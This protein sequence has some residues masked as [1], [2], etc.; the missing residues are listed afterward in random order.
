MFKMTQRLRQTLEI[1]PGHAATM[2]AETQDY[3]CSVNKHSGFFKLRN[4]SVIQDCQHALLCCTKV[5]LCYLTCGFGKWKCNQFNGCRC[6]RGHNGTDGIDSDKCCPRLQLVQLG[7]SSPKF[8]SGSGNLCFQFKFPHIT[9][10]GTERLFSL[11]LLCFLL[12]HFYLLFV[13]N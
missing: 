7:S 12:N 9:K 1:E 3:C 4:G 10:F 11:I 2:S 5:V 6:I 8:P 13:L